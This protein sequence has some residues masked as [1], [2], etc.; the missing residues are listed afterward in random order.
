MQST[1]DR[2]GPHLDAVVLPFPAQS[3]PRAKTRILAAPTDSELLDRC[4]ARDPQA[5]DLLVTRYERLIYTVALRNGVTAEDAADITQT[6]FVALIDSLDRIEDDTKLAS[7]LM[8]VSRRHAWRLRSR[9]RTVI[10]TETVPDLPDDPLANWAL[11]SAIQDALSTLGGTCRDLLLA[12]FFDPTE[13]SYAEVAQRF[14]RS[15][16]AIGPMRGRC[17]ERLRSIMADGEVAL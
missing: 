14:D 15:V 10:P 9:A 4:R 8:T 6:T 17:L 7:W 12:L 13:P 3:A 2:S 16:G 5:W 11:H 1:A